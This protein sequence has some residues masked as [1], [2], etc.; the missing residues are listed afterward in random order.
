MNTGLLPSTAINA[1]GNSSDGVIARRQI[2][3]VLVHSVLPEAA[4]QKLRICGGQW[5]RQYDLDPLFAAVKP[6]PESGLDGALDTP[7]QPLVREPQR[8]LD[9]LQG[10]DG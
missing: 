10:F 7:N 3:E 9:D 2:A 5:V 8:V 6:N 4:R 1:A